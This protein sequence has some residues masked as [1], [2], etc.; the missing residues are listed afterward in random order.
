MEIQYKDTTCSKLTITKDRITIKIKPEHK[1]LMEQRVI[2]LSKRIAKE[3]IE[4][5]FTYRGDFKYNNDC[6]SIT[7]GNGKHKNFNCLTFKE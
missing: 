2:A 6:L 7:L 5:E 4:P 3:I 1:G